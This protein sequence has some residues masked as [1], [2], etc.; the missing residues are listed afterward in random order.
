VPV[1]QVLHDVAIVAQCQLVH[2]RSLLGAD[3]RDVT[4]EHGRY[5][6]DAHTH[7]NEFEHLLLALG[8]QAAGGPMDVVEQPFQA[9]AEVRAPF[10]RVAKGDKYLFQRF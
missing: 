5:L 9:R 4:T 7:A 2:Q 8:Q 6:R 3:G 1:T 10:R